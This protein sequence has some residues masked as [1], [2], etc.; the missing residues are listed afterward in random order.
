VLEPGSL[1]VAYSDGLVERR[2]EP[3]SAGLARLEAVVREQMD[4]TVDEICDAVMDVL[5]S[6]S[7]PDDDTVVLCLRLAPVDARRFNRA[8]P[9]RPEELRTMRAAVREWLAAREMSRE[10]VTNLM[11]AVGE[12]CANAVEHAYA[13]REPGTVVL[14]L[15]DDDGAITVR[16]R[17]FGAWRP[18]TAATSDGRGRGTEIMR[19]VTHEFA[20]RGDEG[21]TTVTLG[22]A[23]RPRVPG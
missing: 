17:D 6:E 1:L 7:A 8:F 2:G 3:L 20:R 19:A 14:D 21:G 11:L 22:F 9:A 5:T 4:G 16:V 18:P 12:A 15:T 13:G 23:P 10:E